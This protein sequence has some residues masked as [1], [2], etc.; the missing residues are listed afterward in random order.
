MRRAREVLDS[1]GCADVAVRPAPTKVGWKISQFRGAKLS[2]SKM[3]SCKD[4]LAAADFS[5]KSMDAWR[6][7]KASDSVLQQLDA[8]GVDVSKLPRKP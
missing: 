1:A 8:A 4:A 5:K 6:A 7:K 3:T 2:A